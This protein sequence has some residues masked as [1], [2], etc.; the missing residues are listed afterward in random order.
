[1][2]ALIYNILLLQLLRLLQTAF[3]KELKVSQAIQNVPHMQHVLLR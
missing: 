1:M 3:R 2:E